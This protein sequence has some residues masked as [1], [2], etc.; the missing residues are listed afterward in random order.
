MKSL[1]KLTSLLLVETLSHSDFIMV[2]VS[3]INCT[4]SVVS[5]NSSQRHLIKKCIAARLENLTSVNINPND[6]CYEFNRY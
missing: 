2:N 6:A 1:M 3:N 4:D 5:A